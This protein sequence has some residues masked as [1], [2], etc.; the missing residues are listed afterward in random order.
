[1]TDERRSSSL[2]RVRRGR[3]LARAWTAIAA[4]LSC[5]LGCGPATGGDSEFW[6]PIPGAH[7]SEGAGGAGDGGGSSSGGGSQAASSTGAGPAT[8][9]PK[10]TVGFTTVSF[11]G[12]YAPRNI[13]AVWVTDAQDAFV[14]T[15]HVWAG[16][17]IKYLT[18]WKG[19][20]GGNMVDAITS[21]TWKQHGAHTLVWDMTNV[22]GEVIPDG[23]YRVYIEL[24]EQ[25]GAG[26]WTSIDVV[27]G[28]APISLMPPEKPTFIDQFI[29]Y[30]P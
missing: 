4:L 19:A 17:R 1:M 21:A 26:K 23:A 2:G 7:A 29:V 22:S 27:K 14:K 18:K 25:N 20:S 28:Q 8:G 12:E 5:A 9:A 6:A 13:G 24:T 15:L 16:K 11:Q 3:A 30:S 10:L